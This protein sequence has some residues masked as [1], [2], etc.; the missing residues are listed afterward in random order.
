MV[1]LLVSAAFGWGTTLTL[2]G[3][4]R[5][6]LVYLAI[7]LVIVLGTFLA[8]KVLLLYPVFAVGAFVDTYLAA[9]RSA[10]RT[11]SGLAVIAFVA[12]LAVLFGLRAFVIEAFKTPSSSMYPALEIGDHV[13]INKLASIRRGDIVVLEYPCNPQR[14]Y[15]KRVVAFGGETIE[16]RCNALYIDGKRV[17]EQLVKADDT[18][19]D[20]D[21]NDPAGRWYV[22][23]VSR[24]RETLGDTVHETFHDAERPQR[25]AQAT[26]GDNKDFPRIGLPIPPS[27]RGQADG[28]GGEAAPLGKIVETKPEAEAQPCEPQLH[29]VV[30]DGYVFVLGD[31]RGNSNDSRYWGPVKASKIKGRAYMIWWS[32]HMSRLGAI[33]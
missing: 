18:Y 1:A 25:D 15:I 11:Y 28:L 30:P 27:C 9:A 7:L 4:W 6:A 2:Y 3:Y 23:N 13:F 33:H 12:T 31:N 14:D 5:R 10:D 16:V 19:Q 26:Q 8:P 32:E 29:Y 20:Y 17:P 21:E 22:R 24:Y